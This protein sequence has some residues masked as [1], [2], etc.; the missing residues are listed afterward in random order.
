MEVLIDEKAKD[1]LRLLK[2]LLYFAKSNTWQDGRI[3]VCQSLRYCPNFVAS[4]E[5]TVRPR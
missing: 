3:N 5:T 2:T 1:V 4:A